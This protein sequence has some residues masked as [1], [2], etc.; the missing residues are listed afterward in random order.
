M[1]NCNLHHCPVLVQKQ[2]IRVGLLALS[3]ASLWVVPL[4]MRVFVFASPASALSV[5]PSSPMLT[6]VYF[7]FLYYVFNISLA[8]LIFITVH[9]PKMPMSRMLASKWLRP[10]SRLVFSIYLIHQIL[11]W[12]TLQQL[13]SPMFV[14]SFKVVSELTHVHVHSD[15]LLITVAHHQVTFVLMIGALSFFG[16]NVLYLTVE[17]P[18]IKLSKLLMLDH[19]KRARRKDYDD[20]CGLELDRSSSLFDVTTTAADRIELDNARGKAANFDD[21]G[22]RHGAGGGGG[23]EHTVAVT[24]EDIDRQTS[25]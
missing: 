15:C 24:V 1:C 16:A 13:R 2:V 8:G 7:Q 19:N 25:S 18:F 6:G 20:G 4:A 10:L 9:N 14:T 23:G 5:V 17:Y 11:I 3:V 21:D 12:F 22:M